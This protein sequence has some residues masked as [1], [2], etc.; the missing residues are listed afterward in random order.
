MHE[1]REEYEK[2]R[3]FLKSARKFREK[4]SVNI[5]QLARPRGTDGDGVDERDGR[6]RVRH[7]GLRDLDQL[8]A[9][10]RGPHSQDR[11]ESN[12]KWV[13]SSKIEN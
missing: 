11:Q 2:N 13:F 3:K 7:S 5:F 10:L 1:S 4:R 8:Q 6:L 9:A 12:H